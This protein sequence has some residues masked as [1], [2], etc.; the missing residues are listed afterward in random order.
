MNKIEEDEKSLQPGFDAIIKRCEEI[1]SDQKDP[2]HYGTLIPWEDGGDDPLDGISIYDG[3]EYYHFVTFGL[4]ELYE[5]ESDV[6]E[7]SGFGMELTFKLKKSSNLE[8][9]KEIL[10][11]CKILQKFARYMFEDGEIFDEN[12]YVWINK[13]KGTDSNGKSKITSF[14]IIQDPELKTID[15]IN[16]Q[17]DF[18]ELIGITKKEVEALKNNKIEFD[19]LYK[20][21]GTDVTDFERD[22]II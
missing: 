22:N 2:L 11:V 3:G 5:K 13:N 4:S 12:E 1:Y 21:I 10:N 8:M 17:V 14:I 9:H 15:T 19:E 16:G 18:L 6:K 7:V 20:K